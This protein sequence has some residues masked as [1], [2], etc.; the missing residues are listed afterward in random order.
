MQ[1]WGDSVSTTVRQ[2]AS[3]PEPPLPPRELERALCGILRPQGTR[4]LR[5]SPVVA[6]AKRPEKIPGPKSGDLHAARLSPTSG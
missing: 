1:R 5:P 4:V 6:R 2:R 3:F